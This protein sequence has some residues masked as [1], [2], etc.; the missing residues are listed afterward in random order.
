M[1]PDAIGSVYERGLLYRFFQLDIK[2]IPIK[3]KQPI[4]LRRFCLAQSGKRSWIRVKRHGPRVHL[5]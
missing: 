4:L 2:E 5:R 1:S 3:L